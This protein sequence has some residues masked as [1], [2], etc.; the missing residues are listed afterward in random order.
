MR[1]TLTILFYFILN[2]NLKSQLSL[3]YSFGVVGQGLNINS[4]TNSI[5]INKNT[6][7]QISN[8]IEKLL[9]KNNG[10][11]INNCITN[12]NYNKLSIQ[13]V[14]NPFTDAIYITFKSKIDNDNHFKLSIY[15]NMGQLVN[16]QNVYQDLF[17]NGYRLPLNELSNG[18][19]FL[20]IE[21]S[22]VREVFKIVKK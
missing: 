6:C 8:G 10:E 11:F 4:N 5:V 7:I 22:N 13:V 15:N 1:L 18:I 14:P 3:T 17:L 9:S 12:I 20:Q 19:Y 21:A 2:F 16:Q